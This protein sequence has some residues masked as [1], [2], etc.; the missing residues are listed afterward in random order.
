MFLKEDCLQEHFFNVVRMNL[1][2]QIK[3]IKWRLIYWKVYVTK[4]RYILGFPL[5]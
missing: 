5:L 3:M 4:I 1:I 2:I